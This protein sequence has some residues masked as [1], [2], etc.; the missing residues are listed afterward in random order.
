MLT[1]Q[2]KLKMLSSWPI[3]SKVKTDHM[4]FLAFPD[5]TAIPVAY[6]IFV[7]LLSAREFVRKGIFKN[8]LS[9]ST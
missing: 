3:R 9:L 5:Q 2:C 6:C 7:R 8:H 4:I 1:N